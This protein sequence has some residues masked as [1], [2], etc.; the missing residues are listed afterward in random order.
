MFYSIVF[1]A[2]EE[3]APVTVKRSGSWGKQLRLGNADKP[4]L[5]V[6]LP[7]DFDEDDTPIDPNRP[8]FGDW[9]E[10]PVSISSF[11]V[12]SVLRPDYSLV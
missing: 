9:D 1:V 5:D 11:P 10:P 3:Q 8:Q 12:N 7:T 4:K 2:A 6:Q